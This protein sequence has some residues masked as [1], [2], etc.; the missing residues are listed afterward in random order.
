MKKLEDIDF[1]I[2]N[3]TSKKLT[4]KEEQPYW[5]DDNIDE[6]QNLLFTCMQL[7]SSFQ[8]FRDRRERARKY[9]RGDQWHELITD[10]DDSTKTITEEQHIINRNQLPL[11]QNIIRQINKN[12][13]GQYVQ[14]P[15]KSSAIARDDS[16]NKEA[17][18]LTNALYYVHDINRTK[19]LDR[20]ML[21]EKL[22]S[23][24]TVQ[25]VGYK[26]IKKYD[27]EDVFIENIS[28][29]RIF[30]NNDISDPRY[31]DLTIIGEIKD[32]TLENIVSVFAKSEKDEAKIRGW[33]AYLSDSEVYD[34]TALSADKIDNLDFLVPSD[35]HSARV[36]EVWQLRSQWK[37]KVHD[38]ADG[39]I[40]ISDYTKQE[41]ELIN[42][43]RRLKAE[44]YGTDF[45][46]VKIDYYEYLDQSW[47]VKF[48]T[49]YGHCLYHGKSPYKHGEHPYVLELYPFIDGETWGLTE[50]IIDQ[51]RYIN[52]VIILSDFVIQNSAKGVL[53]VPEDAIPA[54]MTPD[55][56][57]DAWTRADS[58]I[59]YKPSTKHK[60]E[61][62]QISA[63][64]TN[65][66]LNELLAMEMSLMERISGIN[67]AIQ[68]H[69]AKSGTPSSLYAQ[70]AQNSMIN[71]ADF[72]E[73]FSDGKK[74]R[75]YKVLK[76]IQ[77]FYTTNRH[78]AISGKNLSS[79]AALYDPNKAKDLEFD[80][81][82]SQG[83]DTPV[84]RQLIEEQLTKLVD[85]HM[86][87][88]QT[89][90][91][92]S[93]MPH[94]EKILES[95]NRNKEQIMKGNIPDEVMQQINANPKALEMLKAA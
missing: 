52:R 22:I 67:P 48:L 40:V 51:Q 84:Y 85:M 60:N 8:D 71:V 32:T 34:G 43:E 28:S 50:E 64:S 89:Y 18:M 19:K 56:F 72:M 94:A 75:D 61:P 88:V 86:I 7:W 81:A 66:G 73:S 45:N 57:A 36:I 74:E 69:S 26:Y 25:K 46:R 42:E 62:K 83:V 6:N 2:Y 20:K 14:N 24:M 16:K 17:E 54:G 9:E 39:S 58:V 37:L 93:T 79:E 92:N 13:I 49:P 11:K 63:N 41:L 76:L 12:I 1:S 33:Y 53:M 65:I 23:G 44:E 82:I 47:Y 77:Q 59:V 78:I 91:E 55:D 4:K 10:P 68:G 70:E 30:F 21:H 29:S 5:L 27:K 3:T 35:G 38:H 90:L 95:I 80:V 31:S 87:D 15:S